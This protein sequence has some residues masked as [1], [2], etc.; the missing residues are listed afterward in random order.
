MTFGQAFKFV[1]FPQVRPDFHWS[2]RLFVRLLAVIL[3]TH[4][5]LDRSHPACQKVFLVEG[6]HGVLSVLR[7]A[8]QSFSLK[9]ASPDDL[10]RAIIYYSIQLMLWGGLAGF[11]VSMLLGT[12]GTAHAG[13]LLSDIIKT[14]MAGGWIKT[15]F[16]IT[17][18]NFSSAEVTNGIGEMMFAYNS[19]M[20]AIAGML[21]IYNAVVIVLSTAHS[22]ESFGQSRRFVWWPMRIVIAMACVVPV[23]NG[24]SP[25]QLAVIVLAEQCSS[26][27]TSVW[28][29]FTG[30]I[31][32]GKGTITAPTIPTLY[33]AVEQTL[34]SETCMA[35]INSAYLNTNVPS[36]AISVSSPQNILG[37]DGKV[38]AVEIRYGG[39]GESPFKANACGSARFAVPKDGS[40]TN[41]LI[42]MHQRALAAQVPKI[43]ALAARIS[44]KCGV[45]QQDVASP[46]VAEGKAIIDDYN[47]AIQSAVAVAVKAQ[48]QSL[49]DQFKSDTQGAGWVAAPAA[50]VTMS[51]L[52]SAF[53][54]AAA[55][56]PSVA[57]PSPQADWPA[58][59]VIFPISCATDYWNN[60]IQESGLPASARMQ[61]L[62]VSSKGFLDMLL[63]N[64]GFES[65]IK[66]FMF[67]STDPL[68]QMISFG[69]SLIAFSVALIVGSAFISAAAGA[70]G[71]GLGAAA[72]TGVLPGGG[73]VMGAIGGWLVGSTIGQVVTFLAS[74]LSMLSFIMASC[75]FA[76]AIALPF[77]P[78]VRFMYGL[79]SWLVTLAEAVVAVPILAIAHIER[80]PPAWAAFCNPVISSILP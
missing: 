60:V 59:E 22:G 14:D 18:G 46:T 73:T 33:S 29:K 31:Q 78:L 72:G 25:G 80:I 34:A 55:S 77:L 27:A 54:N 37:D 57:G 49:F 40:P 38:A 17:S 71:A 1:I 10:S 43:R 2:R 36:P 11:F 35:T 58:R 3:A 39:T 61:D 21:V 23:S 16:G 28:Q 62:S 76:L 13:A 6:G 9:L 47:A 79:A 53:Q 48:N 52:N 68:S 75:G 51:M 70:A 12:I 45:P 64:F 30:F 20:C 66:R 5:L 63:A 50:F 44:Q 69:H 41:E 67:D 24:W 42:T 15:I 4:G 26:G 65:L 74:Y 19:F 32:A 8:R 7:E 56:I